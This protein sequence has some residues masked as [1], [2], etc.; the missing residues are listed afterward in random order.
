MDPEAEILFTYGS[1]RKHSGHPM[2][3]LLSE[4]APYLG[5][6]LFQ[7]LL[8]MVS[9]FPGVIPS[10]DPAHQVTGDLYELHNRD[11]LRQLDRY[12]G[13]HPERS[14][15]SLFIREKVTVTILPEEKNVG[16][17]IYFYNRPVL[18]LQSI[19]SGDYLQFI[20]SSPSQDGN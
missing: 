7:G 16:A 8:Y 10:A 18:P 5:E 4:N 9:D 3:K 1:L 12:E 17:W 19:P 11:I 2:Q 13:F 14:K 15:E 20:G 6:G